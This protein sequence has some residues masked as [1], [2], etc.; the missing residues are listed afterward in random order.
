ME[1]EGGRVMGKGFGVE[2]R[3]LLWK[4]IIW[5]SMEDFNCKFMEFLFFFLWLMLTD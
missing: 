4:R 2:G 5:S 1:F 3:G